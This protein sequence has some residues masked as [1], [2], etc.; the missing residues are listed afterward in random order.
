MKY[1]CLPGAIGATLVLMLALPLAASAQ[2]PAPAP[3]DSLS[4][5]RGVRPLAAVI[6]TAERPSAFATA[7]SRLGLRASIDAKQR[8]NRRLARQLAVYDRQAFKLER[9]LDSL[10]IVAT[11]QE[12]HI[13]RAD[14]AATALRSRRLR[15]ESLLCESF[16]S[17]C[18]P[19][20]TI[21][22]GVK[23]D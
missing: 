18:A 17:E 13:A 20:S 22:G 9:H 1:R 11:I 3:T 5:H 6:V 7:M 19:T 8:E 16:P 15:L 12:L 14:S 4:A 2:A 21:A 23:A 10:M